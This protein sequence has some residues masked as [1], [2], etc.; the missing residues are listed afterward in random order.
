M[1]EQGGLDP[2]FARHHVRQS[3]LE[4]VGLR[5]EGSTPVPLP[6]PAWPQPAVLCR[7]LL[8]ISPI[9]AVISD[10]SSGLPSAE[11]AHS[12]PNGSFLSRALDSANLVRFS[13]F[14][15][16]EMLMCPNQMGFCCSSRTGKSIRVRNR[17][18]EARILRPGFSRDV[19]MGRRS[20][21]SRAFAFVSGLPL[22]R[23]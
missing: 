21:F 1:P 5:G 23:T 12:S 13:K 20:G 8:A 4:Y 3:S 6:P 19:R 9:L 10:S 17:H 15:C 16:F 11:P 2:V 22:C 14:E 18:I 7:R